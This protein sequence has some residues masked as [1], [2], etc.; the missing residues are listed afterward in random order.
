MTNLIKRVFTHKS[1]LLLTLLCILGLVFSYSCN[2]RNNST[3]PDNTDPSTFSIGEKTDNVKASI[4]QSAKVIGDIKIG[5]DATHDYTLEYAVEDN[6]TD[7]TKKL[8]NSDFTKSLDNVLTLNNTAADKIRK[9]ESSSAPAEKTIT[10][11]FTLKAND[12][13]LKNNTQTLPVK[14]KFTHAQNIDDTSRTDIQNILQRGIDVELSDQ[15]NS[16]PG[17]T[18]LYAFKFSSGKYNMT[19]KTFT[20]ENANTDKLDMPYS[21][22]Y[23]YADFNFTTQLKDYVTGTRSGAGELSSDKKSFTLTYDVKFSDVY[24]TAVTQIKVILKNNSTTASFK[25]DTTQP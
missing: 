12:T 10:I 3:A 18:L 20:A 13:T 22:I 15:E 23:E 17:N 11:N 6:E 8:D 2:C 1:K 25:D 9:W 16:S 19:D 7:E 14:V 24:E 4:V 21:K 5:F